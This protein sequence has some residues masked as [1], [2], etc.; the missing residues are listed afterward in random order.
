VNTVNLS[1]YEGTYYASQIHTN[2]TL[3]V[4]QDSL[5][6]TSAAY[7]PILMRLVDKNTFETDKEF[8]TKI[9]FKRGYNQEISDYKVLSA[10]DDG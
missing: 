6:A 7:E 5:Y 3:K 9:V 2:Y 10:K 1:D 8:M 4:I